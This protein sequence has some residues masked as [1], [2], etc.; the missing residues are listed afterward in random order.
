MTNDN[1]TLRAAIDE[2]V[3]DPDNITS[4]T[5]QAL[6]F[7]GEIR[8]PQDYNEPTPAAAALSLAWG[9]AATIAATIHEVI[10]GMGT[11]RKLLPT[12]P[13]EPGEGVKYDALQAGPPY[14]VVAHRK[15]AA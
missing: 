14:P 13:R 1:L 4:A 10:S 15:K 6:A 2:V 12:P 5:D 8:D 11:V 9:D 7:L 3:N